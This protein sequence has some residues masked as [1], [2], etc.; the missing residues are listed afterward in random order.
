VLVVKPLDPLQGG[1]LD[2]FQRAPGSASADHLGFVEAVDALRQGVVIAVADAADR[3]LNTCLGK[4]FGVADADVLGEG[5]FNWLSQHR[6]GGSCDEH[7]KTALGSIWTTAVVVTR[8]AAGGGT[9]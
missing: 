3:G 4:T 2:G 7:T 8:L 5:G 6:E 1:E 9:R